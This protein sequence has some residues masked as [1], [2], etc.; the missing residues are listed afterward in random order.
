[1]ALQLLGSGLS[2]SD[3]TSLLLA[4]MAERS[5]HLAPADVL[6]QY[7][8]DRF[9]A[10]AQVDPITL[11][12][13]E[14]GALEALSPDFEAVA[15]APL[16]PMGSHSVLGGVNQNNVVSTVRMTEVAADPTNQ[17]ALE[18]ALRRRALLSEDPKSAKPV[19]LCG[20][21]RVVRAQQFEGPRSF[22]HFSLLGA[23]IGGRDVGGRKFETEALVSVLSALSEFV[24]GV[25]G[26]E[27]LV[28]LSDFDRSLAQVISNTTSRL[29]SNHV[30]CTENTE[31]TAGQGYYPNVC[32]KVSVSTDTGVVEIG[33][34]GFVDWTASLLQNRKERLMIAGISLE[35]LATI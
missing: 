3:T 13:L 34:G 18:V 10:P 24:H 1:M 15:L 22:A 31:R 9:V 26:G 25:T 14:L 19:T 8:R 28:E 2:G 30:I 12:R 32:F 5:R 11:A 17:L 33:D 21:A 4:A 20:T 23:V 16:A 35:R 29:E 7:G 27:V 6:A